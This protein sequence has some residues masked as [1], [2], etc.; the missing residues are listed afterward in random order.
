V[1]RRIGLIIR[2]VGGI[3]LLALV[4]SQIDFLDIYVSRAG[5][6]VK[7]RIVSRTTDGIT[8]RQSGTEEDGRVSFAGIR[9]RLRL[10][11]ED[12][13]VLEG[14]PVGKMATDGATTGEPLGIDQQTVTWRVQNEVLDV[15]RKDL[16]EDAVLTFRVSADEEHRVA[17]KD[18]VDLQPEINEGLLS[19]G[20]RIDWWLAGASSV[21]FFVISWL[22]VWRWR[23]LMATQGISVSMIESFRLT[24]LGF[25]FNNV[26][27]GLTGGDLVKAFYIARKS[28]GARAPAAV[29]VFVDRIIGIVGLAFL[30]GAVLVFHLDDPRYRAAAFVIYIFLGCTSIGGVAFFSRRVRRWF[31]IDHLFEVL[32]GAPGRIVRKVDRAFFAYR[33]HRG[34]LVIAFLL[35]IFNH[36]GLMIMNIA[37]ARSLGID[38]VPVMAFFV[39]IPVI[40]MISSIPLLPGG[41]GIGEFAY[42]TF[43]GYVGVPFTQAIALS[44]VFRISNLLWSLLGGVFFM[45]DRERVTSEELEKE[46]ELEDAAIDGLESEKP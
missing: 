10:G 13:R 11:G 45:T 16:P 29:S 26:V 27:P 2:I 18:V 35:S 15:A 32:P 42:A 9:Y 28:P 44:F 17:L 19:I 39:L 7:G 23:F 38:E 40:M 37:F 8:F 30:G 25:F 36:T 31:R 43:L 1:K 34:A 4:V 14:A 33:E 20:A 5:E 6:V 21:F 3:A 22:G 24:Y 12:P 41:W 46:A